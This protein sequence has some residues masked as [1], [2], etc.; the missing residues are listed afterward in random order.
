MK[1][2]HRYLEL[3]EPKKVGPVKKNGIWKKNWVLQNPYYIFGF[4][5][6]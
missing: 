6:G 1:V 3:Q 5:T 2:M 4:C